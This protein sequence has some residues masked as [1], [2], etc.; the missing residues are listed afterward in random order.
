MFLHLPAAQH[1]LVKGQVLELDIRG[2]VEGDEA[3]QIAPVTVTKEGSSGGAPHGGGSIGVGVR[4]RM[5]RSH[6]CIAIT[7]AERRSE[8]S[9]AISP[10]WSPVCLVATTVPLTQTCSVPRSTR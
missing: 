10:K 6:V 3:D 5:A 4:C 2:L 9:S 8:E 7:S 1:G